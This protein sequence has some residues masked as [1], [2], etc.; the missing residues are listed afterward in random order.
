M[1]SNKPRSSVTLACAA[2]V[3]LSLGSALGCTAYSTYKPVAIDCSL[4]GAYDIDSIDAEFSMPWA[5]PDQMNGGAT[6]TAGL[7]TIPDGPFCGD[8]SAFAVHGNNNN[9]WGSL[10]GFFA[11]GKKDES[12]REGLSFWARAPGNVGKA[13]TILID[14]I[15]TYDPYVTC[16]ADAGAIPPG[17]AGANC[18]TYCASDGGTTVTIMVDQ[19]GTPIGSG[20]S[21]TVYPPN[22][23]GNSYQTVVL[24]NGDWRFYTIPFSKFQ[25][26][27]DARRVPNSALSEMGSASGTSLLTSAIVNMIFRFPKGSAVELWIDHLGF[28]RHKGWAPPGREGGVDGP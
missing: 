16:T 17:D 6:M 19:N 18:T 5:S 8:T 10:A 24:V 7:E 11:F 28:Y 25:Q 1:T 4:E 14:D 13:F 9:D 22:A 26:L 2:A 12:S 27:A 20:T 3:A 21:G 23:C 15:N